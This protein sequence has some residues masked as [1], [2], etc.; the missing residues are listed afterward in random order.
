MGTSEPPLKKTKEL[1]DLFNVDINILTN[2]NLEF[3]ISHDRTQKSGGAVN[4]M[5][6]VAAGTPI[7]AIENTLIRKRSQK[8]SRAL[9]AFWDCR[10]MGTA[11][12]HVSMKVT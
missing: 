5:G 7:E 6:R 10:F 9:E 11:W 1:A 4:V 12:S 8:S 2:K 3:S